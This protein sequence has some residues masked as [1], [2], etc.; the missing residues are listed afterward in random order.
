MSRFVRVFYSHSAGKPDSVS[1]CE[2]EDAGKSACTS[3][4]SHQKQPRAWPGPGS[5]GV[6]RVDLNRALSLCLAVKL[7]Q[8]HKLPS[9]CSGSACDGLVYRSL[10]FAI[11]S[12]LAMPR[13]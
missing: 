1:R 9:R 4:R 7:R 5:S 3:R 6:F 13:P 8:R 11:V 12:G 10:A 2:P